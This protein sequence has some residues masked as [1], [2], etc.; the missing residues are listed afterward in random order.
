MKKTKKSEVPFTDLRENLAAILDDIEKSGTTVTI[1]RRGKPAAVIIPHDVYE[2]QITKAQ[3]FRLAGSFKAAPG[4]DLDA[5]LAAAK[6]ERID[7]WEK[8]MK[9]LKHETK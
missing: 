1:L 4:V 7:S 6:Q 9:R 2:Q 5:A 3:P 8:R